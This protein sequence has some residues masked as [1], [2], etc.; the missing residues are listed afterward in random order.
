MA[1]NFGHVGAVRGAMLSPPSASFRAHYQSL[2]ASGAIEADAA[3][4][5]AAEAFADL[6]QRL[7]SYTP[8]RKQGLLGR[9]FADKDEAPPRGLYIHAGV[10]PGKTSRLAGFFPDSTVRHKRPAQVPARIVGV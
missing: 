3:Q 1:C 10:A 5:E 8:M 7:A 4:A 2:V 9:L 6:E